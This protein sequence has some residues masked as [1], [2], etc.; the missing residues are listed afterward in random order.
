MWWKTELA[1]KV[2]V[3]L[4]YFNLPLEQK[5]NT[6]WRLTLPKMFHPVGRCRSEA[7]LASIPGIFRWR[8]VLESVAAAMAPNIW[9]F[10]SDRPLPVQP[11]SWGSQLYLKKNPKKHTPK[12]PNKPTPNNQKKPNKTPKPKQTTK[13]PTMKPNPKHQKTTKQTHKK[14][15]FKLLK[16]YGDLYC[17]KRL[18]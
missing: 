8:G 11:L 14:S 13:P 16:G 6:L 3:K 10:P 7:C 5:Q 2:H 1:V 17:H 15:I 18:Y 4:L 12:T 9:V